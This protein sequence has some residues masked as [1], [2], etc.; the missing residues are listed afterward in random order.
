[1]RH[2]TKGSQSLPQA[3]ERLSSCRLL[4]S[5]P[6][7]AL[8]ADLYQSA[9]CSAGTGRPYRTQL[10]RCARKASGGGQSLLGLRQAAAP[11]GAAAGRAA[12][13]SPAQEAGGSPPYSWSGFST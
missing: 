8:A 1:M 6:I 3:G 9:A 13:V 11:S 7:N 2:A 12:V 5:R 10:R 4:P